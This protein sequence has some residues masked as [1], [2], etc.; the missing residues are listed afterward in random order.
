MQNIKCVELS[1]HSVN[2]LVL[3]EWFDML[4]WVANTSFL[5]NRL[6]QF[7]W[8]LRAIIDATVPTYEIS[9]ASLWR[10][11][12][13][14]SRCHLWDCWFSGTRCTSLTVKHQNVINAGIWL[15]F[16]LYCVT[17]CSW[18]IH[19]LMSLMVEAC[20]N[21]HIEK[22]SMIQIALAITAWCRRKLAHNSFC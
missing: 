3:I 11:R 4:H 14:R 13:W 15:R 2:W 16:W 21:L 19:L 6:V 1:G 18:Y 5:D 8:H 12:S 20:I 22:V 7:C 9:R 17:L 10:S